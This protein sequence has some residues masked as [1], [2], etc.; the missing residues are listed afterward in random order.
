MVEEQENA[1]PKSSSIIRYAGLAT[2]LL[3]GIAIGVYAGIYIDKKINLGFPLFLW[4]LPLLV[5]ILALYKLVKD[6]N[7]QA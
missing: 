6:I 4:L 3:V 2:Q 1:T 7:K 5:V